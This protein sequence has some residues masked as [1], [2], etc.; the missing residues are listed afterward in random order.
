MP[1][2]GT[3]SSFLSTGWDPFMGRYYHND[4]KKNPI[5]YF[6]EVYGGIGKTTI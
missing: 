5:E 4:R 2:G 6:Q 1:R 3:I